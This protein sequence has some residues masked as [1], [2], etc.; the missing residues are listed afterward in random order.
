M[1]VFWQSPILLLAFPGWIAMWRDHEFRAEA[2]LYGCVILLYFIVLSG[3]DVWWGGLAFTPRDIIPALPFFGI[4]LVF[5]TGKFRLAAFLLT[6]LSILQ[7]LVVIATRYDGL[8]NITI[9]YSQGLS[10]KMFQNSTIYSVYL[11]NFLAGK[12]VPNLGRELFGLTGHTSL[13]P[14]VLVEA[15]LLA[16]FVR[17]T[18]DFKDQPER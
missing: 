11:P 14:L 17:V 15:C 10:Y 7:M 2:L 8:G 3:Y 4:P 16:A 1:G 18:R 12:L 9:V 5:L 13:L 6:I